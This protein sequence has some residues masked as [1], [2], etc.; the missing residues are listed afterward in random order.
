MLKIL[1]MGTPDIAATCLKR[2]IDDKEHEICGVFTRED[3]PV[4][5]KRVMTAPP[6]KVVANEHNINVWQP[7]TLRDENV[8]SIIKELNADIIVVVAYGRILPKEVLDIPRCGAINLHVSL[9]PKYRGA[10]PVQWAVI[11]GDTQT[12]VTIMQLDE[13]LDT[14]DIINCTPMDIDEN[15]TAGELLDRVTKVGAECLCNVLVDIE[16]G[17]FN[18]T[19]QDNEKATLAPPLEKHMAVIDFKKPAMQVHNLVRGMSPWPLAYFVID[20][21]KVKVLKTEKVILDSECEKHEV[22]YIISTKPLTVVCG[23]NAII[24]HELVPE[25]KGAMTGT[26]W[27]TGKRLKPADTLTL[28]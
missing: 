19:P 14:G 3:K 17:K 7:K 4:G 15:E 12:G 6:V 5:R 24:I 13:G 9:L 23:Q 8:Q 11:N 1:F 27:A 21:K 20:D 22:G 28:F 18:L 10:A 16:K 2:L 25:G 26:Q